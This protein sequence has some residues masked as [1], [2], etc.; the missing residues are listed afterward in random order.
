MAIQNATNVAIRVD[1]KAA[2]DT[3]G[4]ATSASLRFYNKIKPWLARKFRRS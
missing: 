2:G 1:G 4:F 3:V